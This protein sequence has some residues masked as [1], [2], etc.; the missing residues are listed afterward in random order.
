M[1]FC[2]VK[3]GGNTPRVGVLVGEG[4]AQLLPERFGDIVDVIR[5]GLTLE[6]TAALCEPTE[7]AVADSDL[8]APVQQFS[9]NVLCTGWNYHAHFDEGIGKRDSDI[10]AMPD[11]PT[12]FT[13]APSAIAKPFGSLPIDR[14]LSPSWDYEVEIAV[15]IGKTGRSIPKSRAM[16]HVFGY[17]L[18]NDISQRNLQRR[19]GGQ[20]FRG[21]TV[22]GCTPLGP[23]VATA[24]EFQLSDV[25]LECLVNGD[26][27]QSAS[28]RQLA[29]PLER[30]I[31]ELSLGMTLMAGDVILT[32][33]PA[34]V[35]MAMDP[36]GYLQPGD[37]VETRSNL[38]GSMAHV[39]T[40][41]DLFDDSDLVL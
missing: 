9:K 17:C 25:T 7:F 16:E 36:P 32:G 40:E 10:A 34:G 13:K 15:I 26:I 12:F 20:W 2:V 1:K 4:R 22:D 8:L 38:L 18:A 33:T 21:K 11:A 19:H 24:D 14:R 23:F 29:F 37:R 28:A 3:S 6:Q 41:T 35:G 39:M 5:E 30:L 31:A 27:R